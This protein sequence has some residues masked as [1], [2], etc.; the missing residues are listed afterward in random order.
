MSFNASFKLF[1]YI[2]KKTEITDLEILKYIDK[3]KKENKKRDSS[4]FIYLDISKQQFGL[5]SIIKK[6]KEIRD[7]NFVVKSDMKYLDIGC[8][9]GG[10]TSMFGKSLGF[11]NKN[12]YGTDIEEW[13]S[14]LKNRSLPFDFKFILKNGELDYKDKSFNV[15][16]SFLTL[17][18]IEKLDL[19]LNEI[20]RI[21]KKDG[22]FVII[23][24][25]ALD[26]LDNLL[27]DAQ[28]TFF[29]Y[30]YHN[31]KNIIDNQ[32]YNMYYNVME[33]KYILTEKHK[34]KLLYTNTLF[35]TVQM[36]RR[37]DNQI[38]M[39]LQK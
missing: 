31:N 28:H 37:Y 39:I 26:Y 18:H 29:S 5:N 19:I 24:H 7:L 17:H 16:T 10:K 13:G 15:V 27:I 21:L 20:Y 1:N 14:Y 3:L 22:I 34:F 2:Y 32:L 4:E 35:Q 11:N 33:W 23:E 12:I 9:D 6:F 30:Y 36:H 38:Y 25:D 8:G